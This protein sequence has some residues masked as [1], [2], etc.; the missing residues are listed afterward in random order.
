MYKLNMM[1]NM[2]GVIELMLK[3]KKIGIEEMIAIIS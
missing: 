1:L 2:N 3:T